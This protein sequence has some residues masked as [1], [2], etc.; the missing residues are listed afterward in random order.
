MVIGLKISAYLAILLSSVFVLNTTKD[1][2][3]SLICMTFIGLITAHG[4]QLIHE[5]VHIST[6]RNLWKKIGFILGIF[7]FTP[8]QSYKTNHLRHHRQLGRKKDKEF[9]DFNELNMNSEYSKILK[10]I[11]HLPNETNQNFYKSISLSI[12]LLLLFGYISNNNLLILQFLLS[13]LLITRPVH[14]LIEIPE[15]F[16]CE[17]LSRDKQA[18]TRNIKEPN[19]ITKWFTNWNHLHREHHK[20]PNKEPQNLKYDKTLKS[21]YDF[22]NYIEFFKY[23]LKQS[24]GLHG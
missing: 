17:K 4:I 13:Y 6:K 1:L 14:F 10:K 18:N 19:L 8:F 16:E 20:F 21:N 3:I 24:K 15:H 11:W 2:S 23:F 7:T 9:L 22:K 12:L 5:V